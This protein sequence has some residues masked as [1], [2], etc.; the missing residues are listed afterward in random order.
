MQDQTLASGR[1]GGI[2]QL[3]RHRLA[4]GDARDRVVDDDLMAG[5][6][7]R[8]IVADPP[9]NLPIDDHVGSSGK[10]QHQEF[11]TTAGKMSASDVTAWLERAMGNLAGHSVDGSNHFLGINWRHNSKTLNAGQGVYSKRKKLIVLA[12]DTGRMGHAPPCRSRVHFRLQDRRRAAHQNLRTLS[13]LHQRLAVPQAEHHVGREDG[14]VVGA[15]YRQP[16]RMIADAIRDV[17]E[18]GDIVLGPF[19]ESRSTLTAGDTPGAVLMHANAMRSPANAPR[20]AGRAC[21]GQ[22]PLC[23]PLTKCYALANATVTPIK[24]TAVRIAT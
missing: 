19:S 16:V 3:G 17:S 15:R 9:S 7:A 14:G 5:K 20:R 18:L 11:G 1:P 10:V 8:T 4:C 12:K 6:A 2:C 23:A 24:F 13:P 21:A 22:Q